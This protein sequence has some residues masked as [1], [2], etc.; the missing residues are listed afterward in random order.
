M[1][2]GKD[3]LLIV[4]VVWDGLR[5]LACSQLGLHLG[6]D[7]DLSRVLVGTVLGALRDKRKLIEVALRGQGLR[8]LSD[9][10][11]RGWVDDHRIACCQ[12]CEVVPW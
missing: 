8:R 4:V 1:F 3:E 6:Q 9:D 10:V 2:Q 7:I 12:Y 5:W 11:L